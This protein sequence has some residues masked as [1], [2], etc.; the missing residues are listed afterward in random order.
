MI[1]GRGCQPAGISGTVQVRISNLNL[2]LGWNVMVSTFTR[3]IE[4]SPEC[5]LVK[6]LSKI[7]FRNDNRLADLKIQL[8]NF[9][10]WLAAIFPYCPSNEINKTH[11]IHK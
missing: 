11:T 3:K 10:S 2:E 9:L 4:K 8:K 7:S 1:D 5:N 6:F